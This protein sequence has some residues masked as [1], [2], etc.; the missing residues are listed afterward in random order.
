MTSPNDDGSALY[1]VLQTGEVWRIEPGPSPAAHLYLDLTDRVRTTANEEGLLG[2]AFDPDFLSNGH[3]FVYYSASNPRR[4]VISRLTGDSLQADTA[5]ETLVMEVAHPFGNHN[6]GHIEFGPDGILYIALGDGSG[7][8]DPDG[9][10]QNLSALL[11]VDPSYRRQRSSCPRQCRLQC[12][13]QCRRRGFDRW[14]PG[15]LRQPI[16][17]YRRREA[18]DLGVR[19]AQP[20]TVRVRFR[21]GA[22]VGGR[23]RPKRCRGD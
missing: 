9:N 14:L 10:G 23:R 18:G 17:W 3:L 8:D 21:V 11:R 22:N 2:L 6:G 15:A 19:A 7:G 20:L 16:R 5:S 1:A 12:R 13:C 4:S